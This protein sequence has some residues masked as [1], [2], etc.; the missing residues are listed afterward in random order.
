MDN[1]RV[2]ITILLG[3]VSSGQ[4]SIKCCNLAC[5]AEPL[6]SKNCKDLTMKLEAKYI[7][8]TL[9]SGTNLN[10]CQLLEAL[11]MKTILAHGIRMQNNQ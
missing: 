7:F 9:Y 3:D 2:S 8:L 6:L 11:G 10:I 1:F 4:T 5:H